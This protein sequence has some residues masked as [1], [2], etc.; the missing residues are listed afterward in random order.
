MIRR[1]RDAGFT[2]IEL[3]I[4]VAIV[5]IL[6]AIAYPGY[7][8]QVA[9]GRRAEAK[10]ALLAVAQKMERFY[11][12][13]A[14]YAGA[15]LGSGGIYAATSENGYYNLSITAQT[16][17]GFTIKAV[18]TGIQASDKCGS[19]VYNDAGTKSLGAD[20]TDSVANC[21]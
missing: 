21:W 1:T 6:T 4:G 14:T 17:T 2:L 3:M 11:T 8:K 12:E 7:A 5:A 15:A 16:A 18:P 20:A 10:T 19:Y 9:K 13:R